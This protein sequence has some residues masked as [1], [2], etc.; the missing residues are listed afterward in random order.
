VIG[1][2]L[3]ALRH[4][5]GLTQ[6][7]LAERAQVSVDVIRRL[8]QGQRRTARFAT[9]HAIAAALDTEV[10]ISFAVRESGSPDSGHDQNGSSPGRDPGSSE[11]KRRELLR[12]VTSATA[13]ISLD[14][15]ARPDL[16]RLAAPDS[17]R[18]GRADLADFAALNAG[19]WAAFVMAQ[20]K[21]EVGPAVWDQARR[22][23]ETLRRP[24][25]PAA[26]KRVCAL[27]A[28]SSSSR[29]RSSSTP[30]ATPT[31]ATATP[32]PRPPPAKPAP[33]IYGLAP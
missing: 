14:V 18:L 28:D 13:V 21:A 29:A 3:A 6:E 9:L 17:G 4:A 12:L 1:R 10:S 24:Q 7:Q 8:E 15:S 22:L 2:Q 5:S 33:W 32:S 27:H 30:T 20:N 23:T 16:D 11:M 26:R 31:P 19:L 25:S